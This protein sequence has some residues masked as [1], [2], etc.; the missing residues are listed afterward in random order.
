[1]KEVAARRA[2][3]F[4]AFTRNMNQRKHDYESSAQALLE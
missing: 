4:L 3:N 1:V 2:A